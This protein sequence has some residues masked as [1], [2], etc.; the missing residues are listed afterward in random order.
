LHHHFG[1]AAKSNWGQNHSR[2]HRD[3]SGINGD[4]LCIKG[5]YA[6]DFIDHPDRL[7]QPLIRRE[8]KLQP[9]SWNETLSLVADRFR[10]VRDKD[11]GGAA[12]GVIGSTR[13]TNEEDYFLQKIARDLADEQY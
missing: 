12:I 9:A 6:F 5:R 13:T 4:F 10:D 11:G 8:G 3:K 1:C 2:K 7:K